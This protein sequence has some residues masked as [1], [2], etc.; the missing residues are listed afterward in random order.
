M[1]VVIDDIRAAFETT[2]VVR[3]EGAFTEDQAGAM[4]GAV[5]R[6]TERKI[7][8]RYD[9]RTTWPDGWPA[10]NWKSLRRDGVFEPLID[11]AAV[12]DALE[13]IFGGDGWEPPKPGAQILLSF[14]TAKSWRLP[15]GWHMDCGFEQP[16]WPV[17]AVKLFAFFGAVEPMG[18]GTM[19][20]P[21]SHRL[22]ERY[23][24]TLAPGTGGGKRTWRPFMEHHPWLAQLLDGGKLDDGGRSLV[25]QCHD[26][27]GVPVEVLEL[28]GRPG[29][30][31]IAHLHVFHTT[32]PN[33]SDRPRQMLGKSVAARR[34]RMV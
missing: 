25:G 18:G 6:Y 8:L 34:T 22:V 12:R 19:L 24:R 30:V 32:A 4:R 1:T 9:D 13:A 33:T 26:V 15:D 5:W 28:R 17:F 29:D 16:T 2:G 31:V 20:L 10:I 11:N 21:G 7:G 3:L 23:R 27:D 14:P